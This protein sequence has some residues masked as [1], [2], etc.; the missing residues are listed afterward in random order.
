MRACQWRE[1]AELGPKDVAGNTEG[2]DGWSGVKRNNQSRRQRERTCR[3]R[4]KR[5]TLTFIHAKDMMSSTVV[6]PQQSKHRQA[7][8]SRPR[9]VHSRTR[10]SPTTHQCPSSIAVGARESKGWARFLRFKPNPPC[11]PKS[12]LCRRI[13]V[14]DM[15]PG[16]SAHGAC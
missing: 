7:Q 6:G 16:C 9:H 2:S 8:L 15:T 5:T 10:Q 12:D 3:A 1:Q 14:G 13:S 4:T 11:L